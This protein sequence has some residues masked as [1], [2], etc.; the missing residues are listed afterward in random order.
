M[1]TNTQAHLYRDSKWVLGNGIL[2]LELG[3]RRFYS[4][5]EANYK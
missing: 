1:Y 3:F 2:D 5:S 4:I